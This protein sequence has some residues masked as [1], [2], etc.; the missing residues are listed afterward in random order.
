MKLNK[1]EK[2]IIAVILLGLILVGGAFIF[3]VPSFNEIGKNSETLAANLLEKA[4]LDNTL[5]RLD[6]ID[7]DIEAAKADAKKAEGGFYP[8]LTTYEVG[9]FIKAYLKAQNLDA[10]KMNISPLATRDITLET[11]LPADVEY[12]L[13]DSAAAAKNVEG[14]EANAPEAYEEGVAVVEGTFKD[15]GKDYK[16]NVNS[17]IDVVITDSEGN[18]IAPSKYSDTMKK[19]YKAAVCRA[20]M[21]GDTRQ[22]V[23]FVQ[24]ECEIEGKYGDYVKFIDHIYDLGRATM[25]ETV[26][27]PA[28]IEI[29]EEGDSEAMYVSESGTLMQ[30]SQA[31]G[32]LTMVEDDTVIKEE[33]TIVFLCV[34]PMEGIKDID[35]DGTK[36]VVD[37]RPIVY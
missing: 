18:E 17:T 1:V 19:V 16:I 26:K 12:E 22:T 8:D 33:L 37:Q 25:F 23:G 21:T 3:V 13:K 5:A 6:T 2:I 15:G 27:F 35:A 11:L 36:I 30:G 20:V 24:A 10:H 28:T 9:E 29:E 34:E 7:A 31:N 14:G 4:E 32:K